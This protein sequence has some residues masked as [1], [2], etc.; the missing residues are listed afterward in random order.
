MSNHLYN[1]NISFNENAMR[2][3]QHYWGITLADGRTIMIHADKLVVSDTGDLI[4]I[5]THYYHPDLEKYQP[6]PESKT[7]FGLASGQWLTYFMAD[8]LV[9]EPLCLYS[10]EM[11]EH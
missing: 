5:K 8:T 4:A 6:A 10:T 3:G 2:H 1:Y 7:T 11:F 9:G